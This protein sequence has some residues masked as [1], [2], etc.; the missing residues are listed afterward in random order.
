MKLLRPYRQGMGIV[1]GGQVKHMRWHWLGGALAFAAAVAG[2][3]RSAVR[4][5]L[6][7]PDNMIPVGTRYSVTR[8]NA[9][10]GR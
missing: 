6:P 2:T 4:L 8:P 3:G 9:E 7:D 10:A 1:M 5:S